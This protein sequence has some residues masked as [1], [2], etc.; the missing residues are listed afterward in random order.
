VK[1]RH[2][3]HHLKISGYLLEANITI[4]QIF[5]VFE[6]NSILVKNHLIFTLKIFISFFGEISTTKKAT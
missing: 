1:I 5:N 4:Y 6:K 2:L 3:N